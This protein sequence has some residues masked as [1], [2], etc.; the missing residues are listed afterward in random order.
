LGHFEKQGHIQM[1]PVKKS[2]SKLWDMP[3]I[4]SGSPP[5]LHTE[6]PHELEPKV[7]E[8]ELREDEEVY[9]EITRARGLSKGEL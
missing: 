6:S 9:A 2:L 4:A 3:E 5:P 1:D 8:L 7:R